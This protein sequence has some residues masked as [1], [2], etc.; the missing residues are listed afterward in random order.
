MFVTLLSRVLPLLA[1][2]KVRRP[3][4]RVRDLRPACW[5]G[6]QATHLATT[7]GHHQRHAVC[8]QHAQAPGFRAV[9]RADGTA[10]V[11]LLRGEEPPTTPRVVRPQP[12]PAPRPAPAWLAT[13][14]QQQPAPGNVVWLG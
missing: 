9:W 12:T 5:C 10:P 7:R 3:S 1:A 11:W 13:R 14:Q 4:D 2:G 8:A 6:S